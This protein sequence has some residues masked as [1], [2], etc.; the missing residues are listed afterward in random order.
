MLEKLLQSLRLPV[1]AMFVAFP[2]A[3]TGCDDD[4]GDDVEE[5]VEDIGDGIKDAAD[6]VGDKIEDAVD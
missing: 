6:D 5:G 3:L 4:A 2:L 1:A